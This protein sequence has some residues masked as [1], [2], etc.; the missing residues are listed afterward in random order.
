M[1]R[2]ADGKSKVTRARAI[3]DAERAAVET[4]RG[5]AFFDEQARRA[6]ERDGWR[7]ERVPPTGA[8]YVKIAKVDGPK[9][10]LRAA[11]D[12]SEALVY[13]ERR[14]AFRTFALMFPFTAAFVAFDRLRDVGRR[15]HLELHLPVLAFGE[16]VRQARDPGLARRALRGRGWSNRSIKGMRI[17]EVARLAVDTEPVMCGL[18]AEATFG[19]DYERKVIFVRGAFEAGAWALVGEAVRKGERFESSAG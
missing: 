7:V 10:P 16:A 13:R 11:V 1:K 9:A 3:A 2:K 14:I 6:F 5:I 18:R 15:S 19:L 4:V 17:R 12:P 8:N